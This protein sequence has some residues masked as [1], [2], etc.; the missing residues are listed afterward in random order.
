MGSW[1]LANVELARAGSEFHAAR[2]T[3]N[4]VIDI[5]RGHCAASCAEPVAYAIGLEA[6]AAFDLRDPGAEALAAADH[7]ITRLETCSR[8]L[9]AA[10]EFSTLACSSTKPAP[11]ATASQAP[12][13]PP[14]GSDSP[15]GGTICRD[16]TTKPTAATGLR[17][18]CS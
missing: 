3:V 15:N 6:D 5:V 12:T 4:E 10:P 14:A 1:A 17:S 2:N 18:R 8:K 9:P 11:S 7:W 16:H 13:S